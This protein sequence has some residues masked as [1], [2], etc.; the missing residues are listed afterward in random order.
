MNGARPLRAGDRVRSGVR[1]DLTPDRW[2]PWATVAFAATIAHLLIDQHIG[3]YGTTSE[4]MSSWEAVNVGRHTVVAGLWM[5]VAVAATNSAD[6]RRA[7]L[8]LVV[9]DAALLNGAVAFLVAPPPSDAFPYQDISHALA[10]AAGV[11]AAWVI[12]RSLPD[13]GLP[14]S[15]AWRIAT[16]G[17]LITGQVVGFLFFVDQGMFG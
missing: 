7:L 5:A 13:V 6:A 10:L 3:L 8:W 17:V 15:R 11:V 16:A 1:R 2:L 4:A 12:T 14:Q 9:I